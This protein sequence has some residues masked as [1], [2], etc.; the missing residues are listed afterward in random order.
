MASEPPPFRPLGICLHVHYT[1]GVVA[2]GTPDSQLVQHSNMTADSTIHDQ[3][4]NASSSFDSHANP[5]D[6]TTESLQTQQHRSETTENRDKTTGNRESRGETIENW[7]KRCSR[8]IEHRKQRDNRYIRP[9]NWRVRASDEL[10]CCS[11][12]KKHQNK[13]KALHNLELNRSIS[14]SC[15]CRTVQGTNSAKNT[16]DSS[17]S[18]LKCTDTFLSTIRHFFSW[19]KSSEC[20]TNFSCDKMEMDSTTT[21][22]GRTDDSCN[23]TTT[24][25]NSCN[26]LQTSSSHPSCTSNVET[27]LTSKSISKFNGCQLEADV[28]S[29]KFNVDD[30]EDRR[31]EF[32]EVANDGCSLGNWCRRCNRCCDSYHVTGMLDRDQRSVVTRLRVDMDAWRRNAC[33]C[34]TDTCDT[35]ATRRNRRKAKQGWSSRIALSKLQFFLFFYQ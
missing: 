5:C 35:R 12:S 28:E 18:V 1:A 7:C 25:F 32:V 16:S 17:G 27:N 13:A 20:K 31:N 24:N 26:D 10:Q 30:V 2:N 4:H 23:H 29:S 9:G 19:I 21:N 15:S 14:S 8:T 11:T 34:Q 22:S 33:A 3:R 6:R